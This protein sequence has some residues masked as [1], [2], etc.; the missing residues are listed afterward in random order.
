M[1]EI[2]SKLKGRSLYR[3]DDFR[4]ESDQ[5]QPMLIPK[6]SIMCKQKK[7]EWKERKIE[8]RIERDYY[9]LL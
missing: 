3:F 7:N 6:K 4:P 2:E 9:I 8:E 1:V 5:T